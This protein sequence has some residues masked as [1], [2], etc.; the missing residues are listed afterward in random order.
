[1]SET[2]VVFAFYRE[3]EAKER[4]IMS[5][6][7]ELEVLRKPP[8]AGSMLDAAARFPGRPAGPVYV[9]LPTG[10]EP[11]HALAALAADD[12]RKVHGVV[13]SARDYLCVEAPPEH[14]DYSGWVR[15]LTMDAV[16]EADKDLSLS[17]RSNSMCA[18]FVAMCN[19][20]VTAVAVR[21]ESSISYY[22]LLGEYRLTKYDFYHSITWEP[23]DLSA[24]LISHGIGLAQTPLTLCAGNWT[25]G[26]V[27]F[28]EPLP[29]SLS[30]GVTFRDRDGT[31]STPTRVVVSGSYVPNPMRPHTRG[32]VCKFRL[33]DKIYYAAQHAISDKHPR[34]VEGWWGAESLRDVTVSELMYGVKEI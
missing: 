31:R 24:T 2:A 26:S 22:D 11:W 8:L 17:V 16:S 10:I 32:T 19:H 20:S 30:W 18:A 25:G 7:V 29:L 6:P 21:E 3:G 33:G 9:G 5:Q 27:F 4:A 34:E 1:M 14:E 23:S 12:M 28:A 13:N 15:A